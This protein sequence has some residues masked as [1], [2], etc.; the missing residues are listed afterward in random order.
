MI[1]PYCA[2]AAVSLP[3]C[4]RL[5]FTN[6]TSVSIVVSGFCGVYLYAMDFDAI[7]HACAPFAMDFAAFEQFICS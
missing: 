6:D 5:V 2:T 7:R 3:G 4:G 1:R